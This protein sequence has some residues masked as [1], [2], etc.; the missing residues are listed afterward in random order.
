MNLAG[1]LHTHTVASGH[2]YST[3][4]EMCRAASERGLSVLGMTD[5]GPALPGGPHPYHFGN[6]RV[7]PDEF[8]GVY[9]LKGVEANIVT[10]SGELDLPD[11]VLARLDWVL[12]GFHSDTGWDGGSVRENTEAMI[13]ALANPRVDAIVHPGNPE[14]PVDIVAVVSA[15]RQLGKAIEIN[16]SSLCVSRRGSEENCREFARELATQ[17]CRVLVSSDSHV[18]RD[19]GRFN[20]ALGLIDEAG[21]LP[22][23]IVNLTL[24]S[25]RTYLDSRGKKV[26]W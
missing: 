13:A 17:G 3:L 19:V 10:S 9:L 20:R 16:N 18:A 12:A 25:I 2:A 26:N 23:N 5:H 21:V 1:D 7:L 8:E 22:A 14:Y 24:D 15:A 4:A 6:L 11:Q